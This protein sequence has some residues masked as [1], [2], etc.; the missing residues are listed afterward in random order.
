M[1]K[2]LSI[3]ALGSLLLALA[4]AVAPAWAQSVDEKIKA[5]EQELGQLKTQQIELKKEATVAAAQLPTFAY[6]PGAGMTITAADW[7]WSFNVNYLVHV[8]MYNHLKGNLTFRDGTSEVGTGGTTKGELQPRRN[9]LFMNFCWDDCFYEFA[10]GFDGESASG[11]PTNWRTSYLKVHFEQSNPYFPV[12]QIGFYNSAGQTHIARSSSTDAKLEHHM[13]FGLGDWAGDG[14]HSGIDLQWDRVPVGS[15]DVSL[16]LNGQTSRLGATHNDFRAS[17][18]KGLMAFAGTRPFSRTKDKWLSGLELGLG[19]QLESVDA[20]DE[21]KEMRVRTHERRGRQ[22]LFRITGSAATGVSDG[23]GLA[24]VLI[25]GIRYTVGPYTIRGVWMT[26]RLNTEDNAKGIGVRGSGWNISHQVFLWSPKG[27]L[28]GSP[29]TAGSLMLG[30]DFERADPECGRGCD[31]MPQGPATGI[32]R[33]TIL[34]RETALWYWI[35]PSMRV[36][37]WWHWYD[38]T[39]TPVRT[40]AAV[41]CKHNATVAGLGKADSRGCSWHSV[42]LGG[43]YRW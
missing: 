33:N 39:N 7:S 4:L 20:R 37:T 13:L 36:G 19:W 14:S 23:A 25:P 21:S 27:L 3:T 32:H 43:Q 24:Y 42:N 8:H 18:R 35:R 10:Q 26:T 17:D 6:R 34:N 41:G 30:F 40:Q 9:R 31:A 22:E 16:F 11:R 12:F 5:L 29:T 1:K 38:T 2:L 28:T 15:G